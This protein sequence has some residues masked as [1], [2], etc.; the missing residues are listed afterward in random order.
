[1][2]S[3]VEN[4]PFQVCTNIFEFGSIKNSVGYDMKGLV[5]Q[6]LLQIP[7]YYLLTLKPP[8]LTLAQSHIFHVGDLLENIERGLGGNFPQ[9]FLSPR[10]IILKSPSSTIHPSPHSPSCKT[11][12]QK[13]IKPASGQKCENRQRS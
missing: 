7:C 5:A 9:G 13:S 1:M 11:R 6:P 2:R 8:P 4:V 3:H 10:I 12:A